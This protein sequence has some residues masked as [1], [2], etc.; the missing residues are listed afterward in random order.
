MNRPHAAALVVALALVPAT[1]LSGQEGDDPEAWS[2]RS[3]H[4]VLSVVVAPDV[5][6]EVL[7]WGGAGEPLVFLAGLQ[8]NAHT[9]DDFA[10]RFTDTHRVLGVT[11]R[12]HGASSW[13]DSGYSLD[14]LV[15]RTSV[16]RSTASDWSV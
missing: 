7:D 13:P 11:R 12:G 16:R 3:P 5:E 1:Y 14:R 10:P 9:F 2:D 8:L 15:S 4:E 6:L